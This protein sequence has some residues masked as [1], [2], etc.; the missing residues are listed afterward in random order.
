ML[1]DVLVCL[2]RHSRESK[3]LQQIARLT[4]T[5][6]EPCIILVFLPKGSLPTRFGY[7]GQVTGPVF[8]DDVACIGNETNLL[9]C[10]S[11]D[12]GRHNCGTATDSGVICAGILYT[13]LAACCMCTCY[14]YQ[15]ICSG[16]SL[17]RTP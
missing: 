7:F 11:D 14:T 15:G 12:P 13:T 6:S 3:W 8:L 1:L 5:H 17:I 16:T 9:D 10:L 4:A 2:S